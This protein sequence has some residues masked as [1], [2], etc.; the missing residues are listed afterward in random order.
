MFSLECYSS[1]SKNFRQREFLEGIR[2]FTKL[3]NQRLCLSFQW[4]YFN[5]TFTNQVN[6]ERVL[7]CLSTNSNLKAITCLQTQVLTATDFSCGQTCNVNDGVSAFLAGVL[8]RH[9]HQEVASVLFVR[10]PLCSIKRFCGAWTVA[11]WAPPILHYPATTVFWNDPC[12][13]ISVLSQAF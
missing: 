1:L 11:K 4:L 13:N 8:L 5:K 3:A 9:Y 2:T 6:T 10:A 12:N 7:Q